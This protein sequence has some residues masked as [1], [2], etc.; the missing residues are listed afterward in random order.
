M[1]IELILHRQITIAYVIYYACNFCGIADDFFLE[2]V[3]YLAYF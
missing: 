3:Q 2:Y 1:V